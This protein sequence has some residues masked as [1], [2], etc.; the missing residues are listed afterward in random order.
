MATA[1]LT[2]DLNDHDD[3][4]K[5]ARAC[6]ADN[7]FFSVSDFLEECRRRAKYDDD[8]GARKAAELMRE[9][10]TD[11]GVDMQNLL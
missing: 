6:A 8:E 4:C 5:H 7:V 1:T 9:T 3:R 11:N 10:L 2:F